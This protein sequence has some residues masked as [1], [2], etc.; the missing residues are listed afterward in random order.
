M[1][2][3]HWHVAQEFRGSSVQVERSRRWWCG[4]VSSRIESLC[5][6]CVRHQSGP[7]LL[8][9]RMQM[10]F[11]SLCGDCAQRSSKRGCEAGSRPRSRSSTLSRAT[12]Y[13][14]SSIWWKKNS[15][16]KLACH[17][18]DT[19]LFDWSPAHRTSPFTPVSRRS[20]T[21][22][23]AWTLSSSYVS[24]M[25]QTM[26]ND[27]DS[28]VARKAKQPKKMCITKYHSTHT[29]KKTYYKKLV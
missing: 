26:Q 5:R 29:Q 6:R 3:V 28:R 2:R 9:R 10:E 12:R 25:W 11:L 4:F 20:S 13:L 1:M 23:D 21:I 27:R 19:Y 7:P 18:S 15:Q 22:G 24:Y 8:E 17:P 16:T 14:Y